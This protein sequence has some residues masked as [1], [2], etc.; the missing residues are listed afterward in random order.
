MCDVYRYKLTISAFGTTFTAETP[1]VT[2]T[3]STQFVAGTEGFKASKGEYSGYVRLAWKVKKLAGGSNEVYRV[4]RRVADD[5]DDASATWDEL[6]TVT[7]NAATVYWNDNT[8]ETGVFYKYKVIL[9]QTCNGDETILAEKFDIGFSQAFGVVSGRVTY[10]A[11]GNP[12]EGVSMLARKTS[13]MAGEKQ[14]HS[15]HSTGGGQKFEWLADSAYFNNIWTSQNWTLQFWLRPEE[16]NETSSGV[17]WDYQ[18]KNGTNTTVGRTLPYA[19]EKKYSY[20]QTIYRANEFDVPVSDTI[21]SVSFQ[22]VY[23][24]VINNTAVKLYLCNTLKTNFSSESDWVPLNELT[25]VYDGA[26]TFSNTGMGYWVTINLTTPFVY[27][28]GN[29]LLAF[30]NNWG[31]ATTGSNPTFRY[32]NRDQ[33]VGLC[34]HSDTNNPDPASPPTANHSTYAGANVNFGSIGL[35]YSANAVAYIGDKAIKAQKVSGG[36]RISTDFNSNV[37]SAVIPSTRF[38][39]VAI[40]RSG[41]DMKIYTVNDQDK[42]NIYIV[43]S[44]F[45]YSAATPLTAA[46]SKISFGHDFKGQIDDV[47]FW[48][49]TLTDAE[50]MQDYSRVLVGNEANLKGYWTFDEGLKGYA[51]DRSRVGTVYNNHHATTVTLES[52]NETPD[53]EYQLALKAITDADGNYQINGIGYSGEGTSYS[54]VPTIGSIYWDENN[55]QIDGRHKFTPTQQLRYVSSSSMVHN[56]TDFTDV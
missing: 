35:N 28:G 48:D 2:V 39:H 52:S 15:L 31:T 56:G 20:S 26:V 4:F 49:K 46:N 29:I 38:S 25:E 9:Y 47:R 19:T 42:E 53:E 11:G 37:K 43:N 21:Y 13:L 10:G 55:E 33:I 6:E 1:N 50:I 54:I 7:S 14:Y 30:D 12:V 41:D 36:F 5:T 40:T 45:T 23:G 27:E 32:T 16:L 18:S 8:V 24:G 51:F 17:L 3:G 34:Y 22:Y 44:A